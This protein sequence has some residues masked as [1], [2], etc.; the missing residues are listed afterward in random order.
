MGR[1]STILLDSNHRFPELDLQLISGKTLKLPK[2]AGDGYA[3]VFFYR[4]YW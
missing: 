3:V 1:I 2:E 4:G